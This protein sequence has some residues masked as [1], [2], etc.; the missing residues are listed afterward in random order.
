MPRHPAIE[1]KTGV[2]RT[3]APVFSLW[4]V[5]FVLTLL[6]LPSSVPAV[7]LEEILALAAGGAPE[8]ALGTLGEAQPDAAKHPEQ[9]MRWERERVRMLVDA[10]EWP[11]LAGRLEHLPQGLP[12]EFVRWAGAWRA[13]ALLE[14]GNGE[15]ARR[16]LRRL[17]WSGS[18]V[19]RPQVAEWRRLVMQSYLVDGRADDAHAALLRYRQDYGDDPAAAVIAARVLLAR[20]RPAAARALLGA[21]TVGEAGALNLLAELRTG[22]EPAK[23]AVT[24]RARLKPSL[25][26]TTRRLLF[27]VL[28]EAALA[29]GDGSG[30]IR[31]LEGLLP[32][33]T[34]GSADARLL[35]I[36]PDSLWD[37]YLAQ[38]RAI[39][40]EKRLLVGDDAAWLDA[41]GQLAPEVRRA[42]LALLFLEGAA[43]R[44]SALSALTESLSALEGGIEL[45]RGL[46]LESVRFPRLDRVPPPVRRHLLGPAIGAGDLKLASRLMQ[47]LSEPPP[48]TDQMQWQLNRARVFILAGEPA[49][50][51]TLLAKM[52][53]GE[54]ALPAEAFD[55][56][57]QV[58][59]DLQAIEEHEQALMLLDG[60]RSRA[61]DRQRARELLYWMAE[62]FKAQGEPRRAARHYLESA[63]LP[64]AGAM[65]PWAQTARYEAAT[66]L[67]AAGLVSD[68]RRLYSRLLEAA[69]DPA[70]RAVLRRELEKLWRVEAENGPGE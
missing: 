39:G 31:A 1:E 18:G 26:S 51:T 9:W 56:I 44:E 17:L 14:M 54:G 23:V 12:T 34:S 65:D 33:L 3:V 42:V 66:Q 45:V 38:A 48:G 10:A 8:L 27:G 52:T 36:D 13:R 2:T 21:A 29:G 41:A 58:V 15:G 37:A 61:P 67:A 28:A 69:D 30:R 24:A 47:G 49:A 6:F 43:A 59:F 55:R 64:G 7:E 19:D 20:D 53:E 68:A 40:N 16:V 46:F 35:G 4:R 32:G 63:I 5:Y 70:R 22:G 62:S 60:L 11:R 57:V 25:L 50:G